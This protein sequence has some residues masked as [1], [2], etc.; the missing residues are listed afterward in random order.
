MKTITLD[1]CIELREKFLKYCNTAEQ[2]EFALL[3]ITNVKLD[4]TIERIKSNG[5]ISQKEARAMFRVCL[6]LIG[7]DCSEYQEDE[8]E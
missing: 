1:D 3:A 5:M 8:Q 2:H 4:G 6:G 7:E